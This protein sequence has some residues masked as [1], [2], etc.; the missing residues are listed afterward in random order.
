M[1]ALAHKLETLI[2]ERTVDDIHPWTRE[3]LLRELDAIR[4]SITRQDAVR[5]E[6]LIDRRCQH[7]R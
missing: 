2:F 3:E 6:Q 4:L 7:G 1:D 5:L